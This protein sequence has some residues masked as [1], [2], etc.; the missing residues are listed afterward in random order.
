V[1]IPL[2]YAVK[3][4]RPAVHSFLV[5]HPVTETESI[6]VA[7]IK[8]GLNDTMTHILNCQTT[9]PVETRKKGLRLSVPQT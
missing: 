5:R 8:E 2:A 9:T 1:V 3:A 6:D 4:Q 7:S